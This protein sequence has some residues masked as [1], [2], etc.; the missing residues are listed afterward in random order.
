M[1]ASSASIRAMA[2][3]TDV[4]GPPADA[5]ETINGTSSDPAS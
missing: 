1:T 2:S 5:D 3:S 4:M